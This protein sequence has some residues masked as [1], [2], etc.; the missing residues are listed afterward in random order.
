MLRMRNG[1]T[2]STIPNPDLR[3]GTMDNASGR[4]VVVVYS[5]PIGVS[6]YKG[7]CVNYLSIY[8]LHRHNVPLKDWLHISE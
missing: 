4:T 8:N 7:V 3:I 5:N 1:D 2:P 6:S